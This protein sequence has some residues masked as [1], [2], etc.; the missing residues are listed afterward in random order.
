MSS[1]QPR[2]LHRVIPIDQRRRQ[3]LRLDVHQ[4]LV[5]AGQPRDLPAEVVTVAQH[6]HALAE[7]QSRE[8]VAL[9]PTAEVDDGGIVGV[10]FGA[11]VPGAVVVG[12][13][14]AVFAVRLVVLLVVGD[15]IM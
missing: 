12:A 11:R 1:Q 8:E 9:L 14:V 5:L 6:R 2:P 10:A 4:Q 3:L 7:D 15:R 13:V